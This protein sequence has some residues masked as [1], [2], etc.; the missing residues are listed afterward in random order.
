MRLFVGLLL[1]SLTLS[2]SQDNIVWQERYKPTNN[3]WNAD[4]VYKFSF[5]V[6]DT[7]AFYNIY[8][9]SQNTE[10]YPFSNIWLFTKLNVNNQLQITD[11]LEFDLC[12]DVGKW[13]GKKQKGNYALWHV[14]Q[15]G[16]RF[17]SLGYYELYVQHGM[18]KIDLNGMASLGL[19]IQKQKKQ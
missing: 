9:E 11:T 16:V 7:S 1:L 3:I 8:I 17:G 14:Y 19:I 6:S 18:R 12:N 2:C 15:Q 5:K 10:V 13:F 4:S